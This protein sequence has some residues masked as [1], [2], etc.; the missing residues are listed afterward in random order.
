MPEIHDCREADIARGRLRSLAALILAAA[1]LV[2]GSC[3]LN[4][5]ADE[6]D[7]PVSG[8]TV[9]ELF[10]IQPDRDQA[11]NIVFVP[12]TSYGDLSV[13]AN[14]QA[15]IDDLTNLIENSFWQNQGYYFNLAYFNYYYMNVAGSVVARPPDADGN[16]RCPNVTWPAEVGTDAA[17]A[18]AILLIHTNNLRDCANPSSGRATT[19]PTSFRTAAHET[20]HAIFGLP[21]E[22]CC[23]GGYFAISPVMYTSQSNCTNDAANA[24][25]RNCVSHTST[26][27][28]STWWRSEGDVTSSA[29]MISGGNTV[30]EFGPGDWAV[31]DAAYQGLPGSCGAGCTGDPNVVAP[32]NWNRPPPP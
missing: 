13:L 30:W 29:L 11:F 20:A 10:A 23:D 14:R 16:F 24:G 28:G 17:F 18:D 5:T 1:G 7:E 31:M 3:Q 2:T 25:W 22:Y 6:D 26:R 15:F 8:S 12:D 21:D 9:F 32:T 27:D 19:E 4:V